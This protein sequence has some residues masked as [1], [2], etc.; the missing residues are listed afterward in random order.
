MHFIIS[1]AILFNQRK[2]LNT[3]ARECLFPFLRKIALPLDE[4]YGKQCR[5]H[6]A[7]G[8]GIH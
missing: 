1:S 6:I 4:K 3:R 7:T 5:S 2:M 8:E